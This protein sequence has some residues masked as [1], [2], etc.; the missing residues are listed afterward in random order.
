MNAILYPGG[1]QDNLNPHYKREG[2]LQDTTLNLA[3]FKCPGDDGPPRGA[4]CPDWLAHS[5]RSSY[6]HFGNSYAANLFMSGS[7]GGGE[8]VTNSP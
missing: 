2:A 4:H 1:F 7:G 8:M 5:D 3:L 6:D